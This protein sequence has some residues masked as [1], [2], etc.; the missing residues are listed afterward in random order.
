MS[1]SARLLKVPVKSPSMFKRMKVSFR[2]RSV[3]LS[4]R[5]LRSVFVIVVSFATSMKARS[6][7]EERSSVMILLSNSRLLFTM[8]CA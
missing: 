2:V 4:V 5:M 6:R 8:N 7:G 1:F 3:R